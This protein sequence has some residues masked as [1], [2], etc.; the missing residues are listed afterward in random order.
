MSTALAPN[1]ASLPGTAVRVARIIPCRYSWPKAETPKMLITY[2]IR[3]GAKPAPAPW[4]AIAAEH[5]VGPLLHTSTSEKPRAIRLDSAMAI[6]SDA[7]TSQYVERSVTSRRHSYAQRGGHRRLR[8]GPGS[9]G[10]RT[11]AR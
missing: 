8:P 1:T 6:T 4:V 3:N 11:C 2:A 5:E 10:Q 9:A 7:A